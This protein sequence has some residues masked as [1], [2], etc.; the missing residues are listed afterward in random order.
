MVAVLEPGVV[1]SGYYGYDT[2]RITN[3]DGSQTTKRKRKEFQGTIIEA[4]GPKKWLVQMPN[5]ERR[6]FSSNSLRL[7]YDPRFGNPNSSETTNNNVLINSNHIANN[8]TNET[9]QSNQNTD[10]VNNQFIIETNE[11]ELTTTNEPDNDLVTTELIDAANDTANGPNI[12]EVIDGDIR[13]TFDFGGNEGTE[14]ENSSERSVVN[15]E[16]VEEIIEGVI[17]NDDDIGF[18]VAEDV[19]R[20]EHEQRRDIYKAEKEKL[21]E[22]EWTVVK[23]GDR[24]TQVTWVTICESIPDTNIIEYDKLG[25][26]SMDFR[27]FHIL[28][29]KLRSFAINEKLP[30][31]F[32]DL[33]LILWPG[34][35]RQQQNRMNIFLERNNKN[36]EKNK[37]NAR[38]INPI[39]EHEF[40]VFL[41]ILIVA[42]PSGRGGKL[43]FQEHDDF[44]KTGIRKATPLTN[45]SNYIKKRRFEAIRSVFPHAFADQSC[46][47]SSQSNYDPWFPVSG[48]VRDFNN[49]R[50][51]NVAASKTKVLDETMSAYKPRKGKT[52]G[53]PNISYIQR[54]P[55]PLGTEFKSLACSVTGIMLY[56]EIQRGKD[57][58]LKWSRM[59]RELGATTSC[60]LRAVI[61][62]ENC[63]Q[64]CET[65]RK[66]LFYGDS[67]FS[68][69]KTA[70]AVIE[71]GHEWIG[72]VKTSHRLFPQKELEGK[73]KNWPGGTSLV[74]E[75]MSPQN[76]KIL[77]IGY[78]YNN[79]KVLCFAASK[80][81]GSTLPGEPYRARFLDDDENLVSREVERPQVIS[82]YFKHSNAVD[83]HN[84][85][86]QF[87]LQ[88]EK[89]W[90]TTNC[91]FRVITTIIGITVTDCWKAFRH[92]KK[93]SKVTISEFAD[94]LAYE[95]L[96]N[97]FEQNDVTSQYI[98]P[99]KNANNNDIASEDN[100]S[101]TN[102]E[103]PTEVSTASVNNSLI[104]RAL[105]INNPT[106]NVS[107]VTDTSRAS[108]P[109]AIQKDL[110]WN[111]YKTMHVQEIKSEF[112]SDGKRRR[113]KCCI[114]GCRRN[115]SWFCQNCKVFV[116]SDQQGS[117]SRDCLRKHI[118]QRHPG[119]GLTLN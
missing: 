64:N 54:K 25:I 107:P 98:S 17:G 61:D 47:D 21:I 109:Q 72:P 103:Q 101:N 113:S 69:V 94:S 48:L 80:N 76:N 117:E 114:K 12:E 49:N 116:C 104:P 99:L 78:K 19:T 74:M 52:G 34:D 83:K 115:T 27:K 53:L 4:T 73:M 32:L 8:T 58:M 16:D 36:N 102:N 55:E 71:E 70:D 14:P 82:N 91:W 62:T 66:N 20:D 108:L 5:G 89:Y 22:E 65:H 97:S 3:A 2:E 57:E 77:A 24:N 35:W 106:L 13:M 93:G 33:F 11:N 1:V 41:G 96:N 75:G 92:A 9:S 38:I 42:C 118:L 44:H 29:N 100:R 111:W 112:G 85:A 110:L 88:L 86:R 68:S 7:A 56:L 15:E 50:K 51:K 59:H 63:G 119:S 28:D 39:T 67:W 43:L 84:H 90:V 26:R 23:R 10:E 45:F 40:F 87:E 46:G 81:A 6:S 30:T 79:R 37:N 60:T 18:D 31:P 105:M 95:L